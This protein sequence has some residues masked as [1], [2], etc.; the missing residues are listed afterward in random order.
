MASKE[1]RSRVAVVGSLNM[2]LVARAPR[3]PHPGETLAGRTF[4]QV[5]GGKGGNQAVAAARLGAQVSMLGCVGADANGAQLRAGLEA[6]G[7]DCAALET[8]REATGVALIVVDDA[9]Q[10]AIVIVAGSN[11]EVTPETIARHEAVL[12]AADVVICQ[13]ETPLATV[14]AA[15][16]AARRLGKTVILNP[17]PA[18]GPLPAEWLP[19]IDYLIPNELEA[20][21]LTGLPVG[22][23]EEAATAAA[24]LRAA[25]ARNVLVTLGPRGVQA[26]LEG[27]APVLY[28]AP[29]VEAVDTTAAGD[30]F[31]G[32][33]AAQLAEGA[34]VDAA[35]RFAQRAAAL[36]VTRA[37]AQPSIPTRAELGG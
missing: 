21:T 36:S 25:G 23:P 37:G 2:D 11:G 30:T 9:S 34:D 8:G 12:A 26:A 5:A 10:N 6:E 4:A 33:F 14:H 18:T 15:L 19:L 22:S 24:V 7:I 32:G 27:A 13:L 29:K 20:A 1:T 3:L 16:A 35:I 17:A 31:I 28:D